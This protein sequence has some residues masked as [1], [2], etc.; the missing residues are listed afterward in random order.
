MHFFVAKLLP[1]GAITY[2]YVYHLRNLRPA[3]F[4]RT[5]RINFSMRPQHVRMTRD[6]SVVWCLLSREPLPTV[7]ALAIDKLGRRPYHFRSG[8]TS[9]PTT[10]PGNQKST[11]CKWSIMLLSWKVILSVENAGKPLAAAGLIC[12]GHR[13]GS[14]QL[15]P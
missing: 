1:V 13:S 7:A 5:Q 8:H 12:P 9:G 4:L 15:T 6:P 14:L 2:S 3:N 10:R 11:F